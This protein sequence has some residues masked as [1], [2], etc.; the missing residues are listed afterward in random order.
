MIVTTNV[1][2]TERE[3]YL[4]GFKEGIKSSDWELKKLFMSR[5]LKNA[6]SQED[7]DLRFILVYLRAKLE[8]LITKL[9]TE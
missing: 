2:I 1:P 8:N 3:E 5:G 4:R 7:R 6:I 9:A